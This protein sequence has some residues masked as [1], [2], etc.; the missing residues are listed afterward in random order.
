MFKYI[1]DNLKKKLL[2]LEFNKLINEINQ[3]KTLLEATK[4]LNSL[5]IKS[6]R[7]KQL[8]STF[9][10]YL[11]PEEVLD[12]LVNKDEKEL[13]LL[14][15]NVINCG[16]NT[17]LLISRIMLFVIKFMEWKKKDFNK[18]SDNLFSV[19]HN[20]SVDKLNNDDND[21]KIKSIEECQNVVLECANKIGGEDFKEHIIAQ[22]PIVV[23]N[24]Q[25]EDEYNNAFWQNVHDDFNNKNY[26]KL[27]TLLK[28]IKLYI[29]GEEPTN[30]IF[31][32]LK[33]KEKLET[34][35]CTT[36]E[37]IILVDQILNYLQ[38]DDDRDLI[39]EYKNKL[40]KNKNFIDGIK[41]CISIIRTELNNVKSED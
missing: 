19:Y 39:E 34:D 14:S 2:P 32:V 41:N 4:I 35:T 27:L 36:D 8:L 13:F 15:R 30:E 9:I 20:L 5:N 33:I 3:E 1:M 26:D 18:Y 38:Y 37:L 12:S 29:L 17:N 23:S 11:Y 25:I 28:F 6:I 7:P 21:A 24:N 16:P 31:N 10:V 40:W 22:K